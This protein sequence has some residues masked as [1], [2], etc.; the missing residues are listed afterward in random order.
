MRSTTSRRSQPELAF[1]CGDD[2]GAGRGHELPERVAND[3]DGVRVDDEAV[4]GDAVVA[5]AARASGRPPARRRAPRVLV[6]NV[7]RPGRGDRADDGDADRAFLRPLL[8]RLDEALAGHSLVGDNEDVRHRRT[9][10]SGSFSSAG[11][12]GWAAALFSLQTAWR[13]PGTPYS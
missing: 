6:D 11:A 13:A 5:Q 4:R 3:V 10:S 8:E 1:G 7:A 2:D 9:S 12:S